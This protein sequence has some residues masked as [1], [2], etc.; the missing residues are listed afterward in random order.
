MNQEVSFL[1]NQSYHWIDEGGY[2]A[3]NHGSSW[4]HTCIQEVCEPVSNIYTPGARPKHIAVHLELVL[5]CAIT[6][7]PWPFWTCRMEMQC[8]TPWSQ[9]L[10][11]ILHG[12]NMRF[13]SQNRRNRFHCCYHLPRYETA[14]G[15]G[16]QL[17]LCALVEC[18]GASHSEMFEQNHKITQKVSEII[19]VQM[20]FW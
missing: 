19:Q 2:L 4:E 11:H 13:Q 14:H 10:D 16:E 20:N 3:Y 9:K 1:Y 12:T 8:R 15:L 17:N 18:A 7:Q 5:L 6:G